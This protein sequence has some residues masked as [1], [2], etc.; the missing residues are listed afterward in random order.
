MTKWEMVQLPRRGTSAVCEQFFAFLC[1]LEWGVS[2][3]E[4]AYL[5]GYKHLCPQGR[6][7]E[8]GLVTGVKG[9]RK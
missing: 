2:P 7:T 3:A 8:Q 9:E 4:T 1:Q 6:L 5:L